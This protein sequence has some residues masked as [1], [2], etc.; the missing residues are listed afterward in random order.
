[1]LLLLFYYFVLVYIKQAIEQQLK[2]VIKMMT[3]EQIRQLLVDRRPMMVAA[4][5]GLS[6]PTIY[7]IR[8]GKNI[9]PT[10]NVVKSLSDYLSDNGEKNGEAI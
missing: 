6:L 3:L 2:G 8:D 4:A 10:L 1:M 9:N 7:S 5:T